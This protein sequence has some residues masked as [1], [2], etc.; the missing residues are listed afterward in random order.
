MKTIQLIGNVRLETGFHYDSKGAIIGTKTDL[1]DLLLE[2]GKVN[3]IQLSGTKQWSRDLVREDARGLL[4]LPGFSEKHSHLDKSRLG[5]DWQAVTPVHSI[6]ERFEMEIPALDQLP[7]S[8]AER[9][10]LLLKTSISNGVTKIRSHVDVHPAAGLR[11]FDGVKEVLNQYRNQIASEIVAF[12]QHGLLRSHS[13]DLVKESLRNGA[14]LIG[15]VDPTVVDGAMEQSLEMTF[16]IAEEYGVG[17]D[18]HLHERQEMGLATF[19]YLLDLTERTKMQGKVA[20]SHA[21]ALGDVTG[22]RKLEL[23]QRLAENQVAIMTSVPITGVIPP[24]FDLTQ[25][26]VKVHVGCDNIFDNW[27][28]YGNGDI[29]ERVGRL[30]ELFGQVTEEHLAN[31][32]GFITDGVRPLDNSGKRVWPQIGDSAD[33]TFVTASCSAEAVARRSQRKVVLY[34]GQRTFGTW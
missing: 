25:T 8:V 10:E 17:I 18:L 6:I 13:V 1:F 12:P 14:N 9:A 23:F 5:T 15:G 3:D 22:N 16:A 4:A 31:L 11:Y 33:F 7:L 19:D 26:G 32:L 29:L 34:Q 21:F 20:V 2:D 27:S 30:G 24:V 28:P